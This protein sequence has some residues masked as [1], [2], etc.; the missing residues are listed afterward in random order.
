V[1]QTKPERSV[2][3]HEDLSR[4]QEV[5]PSSDR[6]FG[7]VFA[8][9]FL[10]VEITPLLRRHSA[11]PWALVVAAVFFTISLAR[12][13]VLQPLNRLWLE[14]GRV[15]QKVTNPI[16]MGLLFLSTI[17]PISFFVRLVKR[18][19]LRVTPGLK[20]DPFKPG[21]GVCRRHP[22]NSIVMKIVFK[23]IEVEPPRLRPA[24]SVNKETPDFGVHQ[25]EVAS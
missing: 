13:R 23:S 9:F 14:L 25:I 21:I 7:L 22:R 15:L 18:D 19:P 8:A 3:I 4:Q 20:L 5:R 12:P 10:L 1:T 17:V 16:V 11:R 6:S 2:V 24:F